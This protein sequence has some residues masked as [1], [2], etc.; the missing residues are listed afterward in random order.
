MRCI[1]AILLAAALSSA[2]AAFAKDAHCPK[3]EAGALYPWQSTQVLRDD[4]FAWVLLDVDRGGYPFRCRIGNNNYPDAEAIPQQ[5]G[6]GQRRNQ[7]VLHTDPLTSTRSR[8][9]ALKRCVVGDDQLQ[10]AR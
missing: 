9:N 2:S 4:R 3:W 8:Q 10:Y 1:K 7:A 6:I 5:S